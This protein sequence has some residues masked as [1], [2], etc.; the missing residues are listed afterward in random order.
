MGSGDLLPP[1]PHWVGIRQADH[2]RVI[3]DLAAS[4]PIV[5]CA[6]DGYAAIDIDRAGEIG[7]Q[8]L[9]P[10]LTRR[11]QGPKENPRQEVVLPR[12]AF[13]Y[14]S[15][16]ELAPR[17]VEEAVSVGLDGEPG[18]H[19]VALG[20][21]V[22]VPRGRKITAGIEAE[23]VLAADVV[24]LIL[25]AEDHVDQRTLVDH[26]VEA[27]AGIPAITVARRTAKSGTG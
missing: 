12:I 21:Q 16:G 6:A 8:R 26:V 9:H 17:S 19:D 4:S 22:V 23:R 3:G 27:A 18:A 15:L 11:R 5:P 25:E 24:V 2:S 10:F 1:P 14:R 7:V 13:Q 20:G